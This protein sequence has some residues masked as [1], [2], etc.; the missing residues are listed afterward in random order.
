M[1]NGKPGVR[2]AGLEEAEPGADVGLRRRWRRRLD[3][4]RLNSAAKLHRRLRGPGD[5]WPF[6]HG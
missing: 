6:C 3:P 2:R 1:L 4:V 5:G